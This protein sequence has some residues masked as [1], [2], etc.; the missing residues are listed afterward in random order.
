MA[1][2]DDIGLG[3]AD[4][5]R[6]A[7][8]D[9]RPA[10]RPRPPPRDRRLGHGARRQ[11]GVGAP[12]A[13]VE[14]RDVDEDGDPVFDAERGHRVRREP[15]DRVAD[16]A[17][18][19]VGRQA[20]RRSDLALRA[21]A[22]RRRH[23]RARDLG[24]LP[25]GE[26]EQAAGRARRQE[27]GREHGQDA[28]PHRGASSP[29]DA[30]RPACSLGAERDARPRASRRATPVPRH[31]GREDE[32]R[33]HGRAAN[34][35]HAHRARRRSPRDRRRTRST[36]A[37]RAARPAAARPPARSTPSVAVCQNTDQPHLAAYE[38]QRAQHRQL[39]AP[40]AHRRDQRVRERRRGQE[41]EHRA[42]SSAG[43]PLTSESACTSCG[44][45][46]DL[47]GNGSSARR[48]WVVSAATSLPARKRMRN[49]FRRAAGSKRWRP[50]NVT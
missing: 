42:P 13:R 37:A 9:L 35:I 49:T 26:P 4:H 2:P 17:A 10:R 36:P 38:P 27:D 3:R 28:R 16:Q 14:V 47:V 41:H 1:A 18:G 32:R 11:V 24:H 33:R 20:R 39:T 21:R 40:A 34:R 15:V 7:R 12:G 29:P 22:G 23:A 30:R 5:P 8:E 50:W 45:P 44:S 6:P 25:G 48:R 43:N 19:V 46:D 31:D